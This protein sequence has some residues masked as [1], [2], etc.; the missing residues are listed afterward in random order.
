MDNEKALELFN[1]NIAIAYKVAYNIIK[2]NN[3]HEIHE[4][5]VQHALLGLW[6]ACVNY[7]ENIA[8]FSTYAY[9]M[10]Y[11]HVLKANSHVSTYKERLTLRGI[12][13]AP[14]KSEFEEGINYLEEQNFND[15]LI[16]KDLETM[17]DYELLMK[18]KIL[19]ENEKEIIRLRFEKGLTQQEIANLLNVKQASVSRRLGR[20]NKKINKW[21]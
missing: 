21:F 8:K 10:C 6:I 15:E 17:I 18:S 7:D 4:D 2:K 19:N 12:E 20:I 5:V 13:K 1:D 3:L 16:R 14:E 11:H 9:N